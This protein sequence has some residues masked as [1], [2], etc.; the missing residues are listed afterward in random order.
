MTGV[1]PKTRT[2]PSYADLGKWQAQYWDA[3]LEV[4]CDIGDAES[5]MEL[6][7]SKCRAY[8]ARF[9]GGGEPPSSGRKLCRTWRKVGYERRYCRLPIGHIEPCEWAIS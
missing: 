6:A 1:V 3:D 2:Q 8:V 9:H 7:E 5:M 4:W